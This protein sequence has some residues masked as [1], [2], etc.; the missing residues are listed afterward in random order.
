MGGICGTWIVVLI[1]TFGVTGWLAGA[2]GYRGLIVGTLAGFVTS[3]LF[4]AILLREGW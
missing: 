4:S 1:I 3:L 2:H